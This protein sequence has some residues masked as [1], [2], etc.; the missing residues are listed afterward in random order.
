MATIQ[1]FLAAYWL[2]E[3]KTF[4]HQALMQSVRSC[5]VVPM[6]LAST[7][8]TVVCKFV[9]GMM[10]IEVAHFLKELVLSR[11]GYLCTFAFDLLHNAYNSCHCD[12]TT[13]SKYIDNLNWAKGQLIIG[14]N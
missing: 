9:C 1:E 7:N 12:I 5:D 14:L 11:N 10:G 3:S 2:D 4:V 6:F 13:L 8:L